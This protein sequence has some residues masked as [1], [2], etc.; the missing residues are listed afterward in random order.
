[1]GNLQGY[2]NVRGYKEFEAANRP[3]GW[4]LWLTF[5]LSPAPPAEASPTMPTTPT[6]RMY[7]K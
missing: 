3:E 6:R 4:S 2:F 7:T 1:M 5:A